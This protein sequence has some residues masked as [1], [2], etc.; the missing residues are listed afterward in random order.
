MTLIKCPS[1]TKEISDEAKTCPHCGKQLREP[2]RGF[3]GKLFLWIF[4]GFN[5]LM[6]FW[7]IGGI[8]GAAD[9]ASTAASD[10]ERAGAAIG[11][12]LGFFMIIFIWMIGDIITGLLA[13]ITRPKS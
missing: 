12:G 13:L 11:A 9:V 4:Y 3:F 5:A 1:C 8:S 7:L 2:K 10:A 6:L